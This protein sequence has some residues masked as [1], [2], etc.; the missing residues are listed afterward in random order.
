MYTRV[1]HTISNKLFMCT[2][3]VTETVS[4]EV[5]QAHFDEFFEVNTYTYVYTHVHT[6]ACAL[7]TKMDLVS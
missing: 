5:E 6:F 1:V 4:L 2:N 7:H 3:I